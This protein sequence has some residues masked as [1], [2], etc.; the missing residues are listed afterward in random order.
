MRDQRGA[1]L[2]LTMMILVVLSVVLIALSGLTLRDPSAATKPA[3]RFSCG[4]PSL[5]PYPHLLAYR[6]LSAIQDRED[7]VQVQVGPGAVVEHARAP[8]RVSLD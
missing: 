1:V 8:S 2:P 5:C 6:A 7:V 4:G 3:T